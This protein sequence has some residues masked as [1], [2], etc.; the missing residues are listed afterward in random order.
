VID[1]GGSATYLDFENGPPRQAERLA[2]ILADRPAKTRAAVSKRLDYRTNPRLGKLTEA[3]IGEWAALFKGRDL[4]IIDSTAR[5][6]GQL[7]LDENSTP[8]FGIFTVCHVDPIAEQ[9]VAVTLLDNTGWS[10]ADRSRGASGK[11]DMVE[12]VYKVTGTDFAP[13][14]AGTITLERKRT[15]DGDEARQLVAY[16]G[17]GSY[18]EIHQPDESERQA[19]IREAILAHLEEH[20]GASPEEVGKGISKRASEC[21]DE[22]RNLE[23]AGTVT[24]RPSQTRDARGIAHTRKG[25]YLASQSQLVVVPQPRT[26]TDGDSPGR[27]E[28][29]SL[30]SLRRDWDSNGASPP[31]AE[32][33]ADAQPIT[34]DAASVTPPTETG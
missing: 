19:A 6:L 21:R 23:A 5:A 24:Q 12:L 25:W 10:E 32:V 27:S 18:G 15:R 3:D 2:A 17:E 16:V 13:D 1:A 8:D 26:D 33:V 4:A 14:K 20:P 9:G 28:R 34:R 7:G 29:P 31:D 11:W 30:P 22:L